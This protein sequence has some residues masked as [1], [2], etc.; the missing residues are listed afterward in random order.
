[1]ATLNKHEDIKREYKKILCTKV[2]RLICLSLFGFRLFLL[3]SYIYIKFFS[4]EKLPFLKQNFSILLQTLKL[5]TISMQK[6]YTGY[7][8]IFITEKNCQFF[9]EI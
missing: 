1:M 2:L 3:S 5:Y 6:V 9:P 4:F 8:L 7:L